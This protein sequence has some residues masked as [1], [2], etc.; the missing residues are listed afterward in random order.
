MSANQCRRNHSASR[1][2]WYCGAD[3]QDGLSSATEDVNSHVKD[4]AVPMYAAPERM[5]GYASG[6]MQAFQALGVNNRKEENGAFS[7]KVV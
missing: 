5:M 3:G 2:S 6:R 4:T 1:T 7:S